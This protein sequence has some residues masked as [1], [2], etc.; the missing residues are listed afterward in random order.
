MRG[1]EAQR[2]AVPGRGHAERKYRPHGGASPGSAASPHF[3]DSRRSRYLKVLSG[4]LRA[5][6][7]TALT[8]RQLLSLGDELALLTG[9]TPEGRDFKTEHSVHFAY[10]FC[11]LLAQGAEIVLR[12]AAPPDRQVH[13]QPL[14]RVH[15]QVHCAG[16]SLL[17]EVLVLG[18][19]PLPLP[20]PPLPVVVRLDPPLD[21]ALDPAVSAG[22]RTARSRAAGSP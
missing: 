18:A 8:D 22:G 12:L 10:V 13:T 21:A 16:V 14:D 11:V 5:G 19:N 15:R 20:T 7:L 3:R 2:R 17:A 6:F 4:D 1:R 9:A